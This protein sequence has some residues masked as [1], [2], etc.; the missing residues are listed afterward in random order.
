MSTSL[1]LL[2]IALVCGVSLAAQTPEPPR[3]GGGETIDVEIKIVPFYAVDAKGRPVHDLRQDEVEL[4]IGGVPVPIESF[5]RYTTAG[6]EDDGMARLSAPLPQ[7]RHVF[8]LFDAAF[9]P[10]GASCRAGAWPPGCSN[11]CRPPTGSPF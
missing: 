6:G 9:R 5:D 7:A 4:K 8:L 1:R 2:L 11:G 3:S 10:R